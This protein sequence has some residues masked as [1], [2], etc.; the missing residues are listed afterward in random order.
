MHKSLK[1]L[2]MEKR[3]Y[4]D[5]IDFCRHELEHMNRRSP[6]YKLAQVNLCEHERY[7]LDI[8][9]E[10]QSRLPQDFNTY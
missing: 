6:E 7:L 10:I 4:E 5:V 8:V 2:I 3:R 9:E 1:H